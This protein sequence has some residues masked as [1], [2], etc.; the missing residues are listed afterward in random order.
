MKVYDVLGRKV[1]T[2]IDGNKEPGVYTVVFDASGLASGTYYARLRSGESIK[3]Q[4]MI[5]LK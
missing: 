1:E 5:L 2:L 3:T 4:S